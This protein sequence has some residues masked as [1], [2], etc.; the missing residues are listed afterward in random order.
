MPGRGEK[1]AVV[2]VVE[3]GDE[4]AGEQAGVEV[5]QEAV[6]AGEDLAGGGAEA[7]AA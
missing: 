4:A 7:V 5:D 6:G 3:V 2:G 1:G